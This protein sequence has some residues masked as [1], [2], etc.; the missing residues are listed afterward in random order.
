[1]L[2]TAVIAVTLVTSAVN[3]DSYEY[4]NKSICYCQVL[5]PLSFPFLQLRPCEKKVKLF[6]DSYQ[7]YSTIS[8]SIPIYYQIR[9]KSSIKPK[10][11]YIVIYQAITTIYCIK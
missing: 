2:V 4:I 7:R 1:M 11:L 5:F 6:T 9:P 8:N 3:L 10:T